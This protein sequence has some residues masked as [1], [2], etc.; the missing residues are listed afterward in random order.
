MYDGVNTSS[1][2]CS[3][4]VHYRIATVREEMIFSEN[5]RSHSGRKREPQPFRH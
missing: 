1:I 5:G 3:R 4:V 2:T